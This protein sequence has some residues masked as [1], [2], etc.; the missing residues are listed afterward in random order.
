[1][2][3]VKWLT[4]GGIILFILSGVF[5]FVGVFVPNFFRQE[6]NES[7]TVEYSATVSRI[8]EE[9][10]QYKIFIREYS[11]CLLIEQEQ[12]IS[13]NSV[14]EISEDD[15]IVF[16]VISESVIDSPYV[17][18]ISVVALKS[19]DTEYITLESSTEILKKEIMNARIIS[20]T[21]AILTFIGAVIMLGIVLKH[22]R[23]KK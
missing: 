13:L 15:I 14:L 1:M 3:K 12:L 6:Y 11:A 18:T 17:E 20:S 21:F 10:C 8:E 2:R 23:I 7:N 19:A 22:R 5:I 16:R 4:A 9:Q